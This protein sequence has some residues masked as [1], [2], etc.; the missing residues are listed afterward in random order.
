MAS[1][2]IATCLP[3]AAQFDPQHTLNSHYLVQV[4]F[5]SLVPLSE[6]QTTHFGGRFWRCSRWPACTGASRRRRHP[7]SWDLWRATAPLA[8][9]EARSM[10]EMRTVAEWKPE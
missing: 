9:R 4:F 7:V 8:M 3:P 6:L 5:L 1:L 10:P 2:T